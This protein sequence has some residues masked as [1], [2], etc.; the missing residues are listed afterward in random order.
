MENNKSL[1]VD[2]QQISDILKPYGYTWR[3]FQTVQDLLRK[4][5]QWHYTRQDIGELHQALEI[6]RG[7]RGLELFRRNLKIKL[8]G[9]EMPREEQ[10]Y[11]TIDGAKGDRVYLN[12][13]LLK[14]ARQTDEILYSRLIEP[15]LNGL[16]KKRNTPPPSPFL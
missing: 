3:S 10:G 4:T 11:Q 5:S 9:A 16:K 8:F 14:Y 15:Q 6:F 7:T 13:L 12:K 2:E 1:Q